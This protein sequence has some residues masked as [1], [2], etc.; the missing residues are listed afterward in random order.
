MLHR[1]D[2]QAI[3][4]LA[5]AMTLAGGCASQTP[6][7]KMVESYEK[8]REALAESRKHVV[9][10]R[11][12]LTSLPG[13]PPPALKDAYRSYKDAVSKLEKQGADAKRR[14][15]SMKEESAAHIK[16]WQDEMKT[17]KDPT[18][19]ASVGSRRE[20]VR[21]NFTLIQMYAEDARKAYGPFLQGN[22]DVVQALSI[23]LSPASLTSLAPSIDRVA[24]DGEALDQRLWMMQR[25]L[26]NIANGSSPLGE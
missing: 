7:E 13:T 18:I 6:G 16:A 9:Q 5:L 2:R 3:L 10:T 17:I 26:D 24:A 11:A 25:A 23:D 19:K 8:T 1:T 22:K 14:A 15:A 12:S 20:A 21:T 4:L